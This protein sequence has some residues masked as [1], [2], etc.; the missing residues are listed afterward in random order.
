MTHTYVF[1]GDADGL[2]ALQQLRLADDGAGRAIAGAL[3]TGVKRDIALLARVAPVPGDSCTVLDVSLDVNRAALLALLEAGVSVEYFD[4]HFAG[5]IPAHP[6][7]AAHI[8]LAP[9]VC[10]SILVDRH[11]EGRCRVWAAVGA[12]GDSLN[13]EGRALAAA[14]GVSGPGAEQLRAIGVA[15]NYNAYGESVADLH[16]PPVDLA[17]EMLRFPDPLEMAERSALFRRVADGFRADMALAGRVQP[18]RRAAGAV[19]FVLPDA[20]WSRRVSG[21]LANDLAK[22]HA[23][24]AVALLS[25]RSSEAGGGYVVSIRVPRDARISAEAFCRRFPTGGGRRTAAGINHLPAD[26]LDDFGAAFESEFRAAV[27]E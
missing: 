19:L 23:G 14:A 5:D 26:A 20:A 11:L 2:C 13:D 3:V 25:P 15:V 16:V 27:P 9:N 10:T 1:N 22:A 12:F 6:G 21:T 18:A 4:H 24:D 7:L 8:D 17:E